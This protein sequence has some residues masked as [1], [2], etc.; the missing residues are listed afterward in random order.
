[1]AFATELQALLNETLPG[2]HTIEST[3]SESDHRYVVR[4]EGGRR[5]A[6]HVRGDHLADL[7]VTMYLDHD[8]TQQYLK[9]VRSDVIVLSVLDRRPL[10]RYEY[11]SDMRV[12]PI[13]HWQVH[14]E[15]GALSHLLARAHA[16]DPRSVP[17]PHDISSLHLPVGGERFRPCLEDVLQFLITNCGIDSVPG[18]EAAVQR[19]REQWRR[20]QLGSA[21]RDLPSEAA[22]VLQGLG[23]HVE[24]P[25]PHHPL[26]PERVEVMRQW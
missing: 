26:L 2:E 22:R 11:R 24:P 1:M 19:G 3:R 9:T 18:W 20:R 17:R 16:H 21:V 23:W 12:T 25:P 4:P 14:A 10:F 7:G 8:R 6:L 5:L 13:A 15:R